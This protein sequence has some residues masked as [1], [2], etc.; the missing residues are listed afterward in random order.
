VLDWFRLAHHL[1]LTIT[2][3]QRKVTSTEFIQWNEFF[4]RQWNEPTKQDYYLAMLASELR[5]VFSSKKRAIKVEDSILKFHF[6]EKVEKEEL[7][8]EDKLKRSKAFWLGCLG[9]TSNE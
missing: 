5:Q 6:V 1:H 3:V 4:K 2:E 7:T 8:P 9:I